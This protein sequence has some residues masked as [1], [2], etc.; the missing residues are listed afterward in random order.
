MGGERR[1]RTPEGTFGEWEVLR[2][3]GGYNTGGSPIRGHG[4]KRRGGWWWRGPLG[5]CGRDGEGT[6]HVVGGGPFLTSSL[7]LSIVQILLCTWNVCI[8]T[9]E[10]SPSHV[11]ST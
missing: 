1:G 3:K 10:R 4:L 9:F 8:S 2:E 5:S 7:H 11:W 6:A